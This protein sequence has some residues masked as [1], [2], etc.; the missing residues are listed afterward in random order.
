[1]KYFSL[2]SNSVGSRLIGEP[3]FKPSG[4]K[5]VE[6]LDGETL[7]KVCNEKTAVLALGKELTAFLNGTDIST[8]SSTASM[9]SDA[10]QNYSQV[11]RTTF[12]DYLSEANCK[13]W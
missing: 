9:L 3:I 5:S 12:K 10:S 8:K 11:E 2:F 6:R 1:L 7:K 13:V 4:F